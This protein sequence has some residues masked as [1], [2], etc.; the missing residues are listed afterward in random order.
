MSVVRGGGATG[1]AQTTVNF[2]YDANGNLTA[3]GTYAYTYGPLNRLV[4]VRSAATNQ[5]VAQYF[6]D[7][8][9]QRAAK[10]TYTSGT[11][12]AYTQYL[13]NGSA[14]VLER[15][16][17]LPGPTA[18]SEKV[19]VYVAGTMAVTR[20][21]TYATSST[22]YTYYAVDHLGTVRA[23]ATV[24]SSG[25]YTA[26]GTVIHDFEPFGVEI[27]PTEPDGNTHD[28]TGQERDPE[29]GND[30]MH[31]RS[32]ESAMG[33]FMRPDNINGT[34]MNPQSW[35]LYSYVH[36]N[37][38]TFNDPTGHLGSIEHGG[39]QINPDVGVGE[40]SSPWN[41]RFKMVDPLNVTVRPSSKSSQ[42]PETDMQRWGD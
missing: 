35:N 9:G 36:G 10:I 5:L 27:A 12:S 16:W 41:Q 7:A 34:A 31:F 26:Q 20:Q 6:Y 8:S 14:V 30:Y 22:T 25:N 17:S 40:P 18:Q 24:D 11:A 39:T 32:F 23:T 4:A 28:F 42:Q 2:Q 19:Y 3:D 1:E 21:T 37:P 15:T 38:V 13:R 29:T 33:R